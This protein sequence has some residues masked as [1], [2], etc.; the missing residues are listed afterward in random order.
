MPEILGECISA[1]KTLKKVEIMKIL[2]QLHQQLFTT[3]VAVSATVEET[4]QELNEVEMAKISGGFNP[5]PEPPGI[6]A[7]PSF[8]FF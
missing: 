2:K 5:Q 8:R 6:T 3:K 4:I 7:R 1:T